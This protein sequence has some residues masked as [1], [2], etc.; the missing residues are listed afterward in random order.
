MVEILDKNGILCPQADNL[1]K[2]TISDIGY[3][4][5]V[6]NGNPASLEPFKADFRK[7]FNGKCM[8]IV[9][10]NKKGTIKITASSNNITGSHTDILSI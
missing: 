10:S 8:L 9:G 2:F 6:G 1:I 7:A 3:I 4:A 5:G